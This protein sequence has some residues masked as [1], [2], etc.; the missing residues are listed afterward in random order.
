MVGMTAAAQPT[1]FQAM[2]NVMAE[3]TNVEK[4]DR[5]DGGQ[6]GAKFNFRGVDRTVKAL[7]AAIRKHKVLIIPEKTTV[8]W[9]PVTTSQGKPAGRSEVT[10]TYRIY[11]PAGDS[12]PME[13]P[14]EAMDS[15]DKSVSK[16]MS[17]AWRTGLLQ[18]FFL[19]TGDPEPDTQEYEMGVQAQ[20]ENG[21]RGAAAASQ[22]YEG[23]LA[24][25]NAA[26]DAAVGDH[27]ALLKLYNE[28][29]K[30][31]A[32]QEIKARILTEGNKAKGARS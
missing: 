31:K 7:S 2:Q 3:V 1:V 24:D 22:R 10:V 16:A 11:G 13:V 32:P 8:A 20:G 9:Q 6:H 29:G 30:Q 26:I 23:V 14:G 5:F 18:A 27:G 19:P 17:V 21:F 4:G 15:G 25:W 12:I 28:A